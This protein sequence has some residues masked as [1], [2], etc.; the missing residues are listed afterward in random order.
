LSRGSIVHTGSV[1]GNSRKTF[2][3]NVPV[4]DKMAPNA[5]IVTYYVRND[6]EIVTDSISFNVAGVFQNQV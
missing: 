2:T 3:F 1:N 5:R 6:G 4:T